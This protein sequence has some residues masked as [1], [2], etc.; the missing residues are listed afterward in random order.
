MINCSLQYK[1]CQCDE[2]VGAEAFGRYI[3]HFF[4]EPEIQAMHQIICTFSFHNLP[5]ICTKD[6]GK[7]EMNN[8]FLKVVY[9]TVYIN[10]WKRMCTKTKKYAV[11]DLLFL[12]LHVNTGRDD[13]LILY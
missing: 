4:L 12:Q 6:V 7:Q 10:R 3:R 2:H 5:I 11:Q 13:N 9:C 1:E 8:A